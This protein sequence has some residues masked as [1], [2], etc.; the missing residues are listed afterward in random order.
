MDNL[1]G[2]KKVMFSGRVRFMEG[3]S[4]RSVTAR[5]CSFSWHDVRRTGLNTPLD[6]PSGPVDCT[7]YGILRRPLSDRSVHR[8]NRK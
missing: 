3:T 6:G 7:V 5:A 4:A 1:S 8:W 2:L